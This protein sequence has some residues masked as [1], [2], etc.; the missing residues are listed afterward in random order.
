MRITP[1]PFSRTKKAVGILAAA[2]VVFTLSLGVRSVFSDEG[3][4]VTATVGTTNVPP[5][6]VSVNPSNSPI[7][8]PRNSS[9][10]VSITVADPDSTSIHYTVTAGSGIT[11][12]QNGT[13]NLSGGRA[14]VDFTYYAPTTKAKL[15][16]VTVTLDDGSGGTPTVRTVD[17]YV[18]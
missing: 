1:S 9:Q 7:T 11:I 10:T 18:Y 13:V 12:P 3:V 14:Y 8:V 5:S 17:L 15:V 4:M 2:L 6:V 16:P